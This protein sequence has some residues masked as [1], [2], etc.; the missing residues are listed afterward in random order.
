MDREEEEYE[1]DNHP[2]GS[3]GAVPGPSADVLRFIDILMTLVVPQ[4]VPN[5]SK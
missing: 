3:P 2:A 1:K 5:K 4:K